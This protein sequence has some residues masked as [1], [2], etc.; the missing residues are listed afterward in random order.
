MI[1]VTE[2]QELFEGLP[3]DMEIEFC[4]LNRGGLEVLSAYE[5]D[6][7]ILVDI[8]TDEDDELN[9]KALL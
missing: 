1:T 5:H 6:G 8:G 7:R 3:G 2:L 9:M 4:T